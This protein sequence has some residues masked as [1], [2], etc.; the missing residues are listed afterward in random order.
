MIKKYCL[1]LLVIS[2]S[3]TK[4]IQSASAADDSDLIIKIK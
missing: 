2:F 1:L 3:M 4:N